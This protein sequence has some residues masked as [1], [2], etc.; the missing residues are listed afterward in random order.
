MMA[1]L[2]V[3]GISVFHVTVAM[4]TAFETSNEVPE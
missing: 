4:A 2:L 1:V 3:S